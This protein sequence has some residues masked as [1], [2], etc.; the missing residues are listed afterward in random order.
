MFFLLSFLCVSFE[1]TNKPII[2]TDSNFSKVIKEIPIAF[3]YLLKKKISFCEESLPDFIEASKIMNGTVQFVIMDCDDSR[4]TFDKYGFNAY[5][6]Y[7]VFRNGTVTYEYPYGREAYSIVQYLE[8]IS[9]K[10]VISIN[11]G[12][13]LR[14]FIDR[15]DHVI[16]LAAE[17][18]DPELLSIY[19]EVAIKLKDRIPFVVV[20]DPDAIEMLNVETTPIIQL[21]RNQDRKVINFQLTVKEFN[22]GDLE[23][24]IYNNITPRYKARNSIAFR[25]L[26][27]DPRFT[28]LAF[29]DSSKKK[30]LDLLHKIMNDVVEEFDQNFSYLYCDIYDMGNIV[31]NLGFLG[32]HDPCFAIVKL[33]NGEIRDKHLLSDKYDATPRR[34]LNFVRKFYNNTINKQYKSEPIDEPPS[35]QNSTVKK[36][37]GSNFVEEVTNI[38]YDKLILCIAKDNEDN[39]KALQNV[40]QVADDFQRQKVESVIFYYIDLTKNEIPLKLPENKPGYPELIFWPAGPK[41]QPNLLHGNSTSREI[42]AYVLDLSKT[43]YRYKVPLNLMKKRIGPDREFTSEKEREEFEDL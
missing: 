18:I 9:G 29:V 11:N 37:V 32:T 2:L 36:L 20:V 4:K 38:S 28:L 14:D 23:T 27:H 16:V 31:L 30:S 1:T 41:A 5:P 10:D 24:W 22:K 7:F 21:Y 26:N 39:K 15:Q 13:D 3:L 17:D 19:T 8:R 12:R 40:K 35:Q 6:S 25:D 42:I 43:K 34:V 33:T